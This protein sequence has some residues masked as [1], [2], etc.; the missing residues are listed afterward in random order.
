VLKQIA[1]AT[2]GQQFEGDPETISH[3]YEQIATFF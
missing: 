1:E 3:I 2:G